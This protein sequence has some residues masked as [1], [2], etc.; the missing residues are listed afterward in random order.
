[1]IPQIQAAAASPE[2]WAAAANSPG[3]PAVSPA[4]A[5]APQVAPAMP[6]FTPPQAKYSMPTWAAGLG[7][8]RMQPLYQ[9]RPWGGGGLGFQPSVGGYTGLLNGM[10]RR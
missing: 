8:N 4:P 6:A 1:M 3:L 7:G 5:P 9:F 2:A 10:I